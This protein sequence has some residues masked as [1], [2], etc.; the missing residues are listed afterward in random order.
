MERTSKCL[1]LKGNLSPKDLD[2]SY[3]IS[4]NLLVKGSPLLNNAI[5]VF[6]LL[7]RKKKTKTFSSVQQHKQEAFRLLINTRLLPVHFTQHSKFINLI[8][9]HA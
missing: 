6:F 4:I 1:G 9:F 7:K 5:R 2:G 8:L 3:D